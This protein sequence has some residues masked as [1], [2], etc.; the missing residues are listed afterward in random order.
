MRLFNVITLITVAFLLFAASRKARKGKSVMMLVGLVFLGAAVWQGYKMFT[1]QG[2]GDSQSSI[3]RQVRDTSAIEGRTA[4]PGFLSTGPA[5]LEMT[6]S[7][8]QYYVTEE[9]LA[10]L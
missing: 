4:R 6:M 9:T 8:R 7:G 5:N 2:S 1:E 10:A 3:T